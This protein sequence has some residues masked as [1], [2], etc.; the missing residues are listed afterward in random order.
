MSIK[1]HREVISQNRSTL[2]HFF[3]DQ[4]FILKY[5]KVGKGSYKVFQ[6]PYRWDHSFLLINDVRITDFQSVILYTNELVVRFSN[7]DDWQINIPYKVIKTI[8]VTNDLD[9]GYQQLHLNK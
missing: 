8:S 2:Y 6:V 5:M 7:Y 9:V 4:D 3:K 1:E